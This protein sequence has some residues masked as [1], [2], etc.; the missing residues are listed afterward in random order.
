MNLDISN[1]SIYS[2]DLERNFGDLLVSDKGKET[3]TRKEK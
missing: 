2:D 3:L 1:E